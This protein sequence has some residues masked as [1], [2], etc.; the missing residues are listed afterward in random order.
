MELLAWTTLPVP[1]DLPY[2]K[3]ERAVK[4]CQSWLVN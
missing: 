1:S 2:V 3:L 4:P